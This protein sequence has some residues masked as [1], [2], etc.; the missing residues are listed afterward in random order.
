MPLFS[1]SRPL[2]GLLYCS[3][4]GQATSQDLNPLAWLNVSIDGQLKEARPLAAPCF[5]NPNSTDCLSLKN[6]LALGHPGL[7]RMNHYAGFQYT[8]G[9]SCAADP[10]D[11]CLLDASTLTPASSNARCR[12]GVVS[13]NYVE[14]TGP[15]DVQ[16]MFEYAQRTVAALSI[17]NSG[18]DYM[19][20]SSRQGSLAIW[21][22]GLREMAYDP[23]FIP[24]GCADDYGSTGALTFGAGVSMD[25]A[26]VFAHKNGVLFAGG[27]VATIGASGGWVL[28][29]GHGVLSGSLGLGAD[30]V[31]QYS[32][33][34]PDGQVRIANKCTN[35]DLFWA[36]RG[37]GGGAFGV[38]LSSTQQTEAEKPLTAVMLTF[39]GTADNVRLYLSILAEHMRDWALEGWGGPSGSNYS[40]LGNVYVNTSQAETTMAPVIE[41][42]RS[43]NGSAIVQRYETFF[44][45]YT[46]IMNG[47][48]A[49][50]E[51]ISTATFA[52]NRAIPEAVFQETTSREQMVDAIIETQRA[53]LTPNLLTTTPLLY[54]RT[55]PDPKTSLHPAWYK[56]VW[57]VVATGGWS[58]DSSLSDRRAFVSSLRNTTERWKAIAP[59]GFSYPN[60]ADPWIEDWSH[61]FWGDNYRR[62]LEVKNKVDPN[63]LLSCWHCVGW[64]ESLPNYECISGLA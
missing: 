31:L 56:S 27:T 55:H 47:T 16:A 37:G 11:Q 24:E 42:V 38:V 43:Q 49:A 58:P 52:T 1:F 3:L 14:V 30:R 32:I 18:H 48:F 61:Q 7:L 23:S 19:A 36:L 62:L 50:P 41:Y 54:G 12:Q 45:Y 40:V 22:R 20:R 63:G 17:K 35:P 26:Y 4:I 64:N 53:G 51:P 15:H 59:D 10:R 39:P 33:V 21:T 9:E 29:G 13:P 60:E 2:I 25:E 28:N 57:L 34:T 5:S 6:A 44:D 46:E 8:Q